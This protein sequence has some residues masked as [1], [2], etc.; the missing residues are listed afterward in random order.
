MALTTLELVTT[1]PGSPE[2]TPHNIDV[3]TPQAR[4]ETLV[5]ALGGISC[6]SLRA[7]VAESSYAHVVDDYDPSRPVAMVRRVL[8]LLRQ[9]EESTDPHEY[10]ALFIPIEAG[11]EPELIDPAAVT[12][13]KEFQPDLAQPTD[14][15]MPLLNGAIELG[16]PNASP[17]YNGVLHRYPVGTMM[18]VQDFLDFTR[19]PRYLRRESHEDIT[20]GLRQLGHLTLT[21]IFGHKLIY[22]VANPFGQ[23]HYRIQTTRNKVRREPFTLG[24][25]YEMSVTQYI[26]ADSKAVLMG[27]GEAGVLTG[28]Y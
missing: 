11:N 18:G 26:T 25:S 3:V 4:R 2:T 14:P 21:E 1:A 24:P 8:D 17:V 12:W 22:R 28:F 13:P 19:Q 20:G 10:H 5:F 15:I 7:L 27:S 23:M 9:L 6:D 16:D